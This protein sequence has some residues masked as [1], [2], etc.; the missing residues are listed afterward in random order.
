MPWGIHISHSKV[1]S[2]EWPTKSPGGSEPGQ[3]V[4][5]WPSLQV[6]PGGFQVLV[7]TKK[8]FQCMK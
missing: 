1:T 3:A 7:S 2:T 6:L 5:H 4:G 8:L